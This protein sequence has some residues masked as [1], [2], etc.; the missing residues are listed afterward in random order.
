MSH[1]SYQGPISADS[2]AQSGTNALPISSTEIVGE[3][4]V[5]HAVSTEVDI[6]DD[7]TCRAVR[8]VWLPHAEVE[9]VAPES[10]P[11]VELSMEALA[12]MPDAATA[13]GALDPLVRQI[14]RV[15]RGAASRA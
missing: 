11:D 10:I 8:T 5:G 3:F 12:S 9:R 4:A 1:R 6:A 14:P 15:D 7:G 2:K 13:Q